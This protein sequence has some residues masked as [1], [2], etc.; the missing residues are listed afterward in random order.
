M[1]NNTMTYQGYV[2]SIVFDPRDEIFVGK[3]LGVCDSITFHGSTV[4][5]LTFDFHQ[6][7]DHYLADC[8][9]SHRP[10]EKPASG[11]MMLRVPPEV[12]TAA[13]IAAKAAGKSLNQWASDALGQAAHGYLTP[14][15]SAAN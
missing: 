11:K 13:T 6:A 5:E 14:S 3:V 4:A 12:H 9:A 2:A 10:P 8:K 7:I 1:T 15:G